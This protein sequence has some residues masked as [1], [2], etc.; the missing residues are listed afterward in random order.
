MKILSINIEDFIDLQMLDDETL[1]AV[2][3]VTANLA[4]QLHSM[5]VAKANASLHLS[6]QTY[7]GALSQPRKISRFHWEIELADEADWIEEGIP[8]N[9]D[10]LPGL[11][12]SPKAKQ[13]KNGR[14][15][16]IPFNHSK[17]GGAE[18]TSKAFALNQQLKSAMKKAKIPFRK[19]ET[20]AQ[21]VPKQGLLHK[22]DVMTTPQHKKHSKKDQQPLGHPLISKPEGRS[23]LQGV[24]VYQS[25]NAKG[26]VEKTN[27][28][29]RI[30][31][32]K[33]SGKKWIHP[34]TSGL[35]A[36]DDAEA[37]A[38]ESWLDFFGE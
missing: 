26:K 31:H 21:G 22:M 38:Q 15:I 4:T 11:L 29:F 12:A 34:G 19:V 30:A 14:Y 25:K 24:R 18:K 33:H 5:I 1:D 32:E 27:F 9:F 36:F 13:G 10:M 37:F 35:H 17:G 6:K 7:L 28:T 2:E 3:E 20:D 16:I 8:K 23:Y